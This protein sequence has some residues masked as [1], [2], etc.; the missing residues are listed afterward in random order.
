MADDIPFSP[1]STI[2]DLSVLD[3]LKALMLANQIGS[4][5]LNKV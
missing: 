3:E 1:P 4:N 2:E 5:E